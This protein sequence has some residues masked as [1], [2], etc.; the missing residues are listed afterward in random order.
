MAGTVSCHIQFTTADLGTSL[1]LMSREA[2]VWGCDSHLQRVTT[3]MTN[4]CSS[5]SK[6]KI[7]ILPKVA[8]IKLL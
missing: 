6:L 4:L 2:S 7:T 8:V 5:C 3:E 1:E